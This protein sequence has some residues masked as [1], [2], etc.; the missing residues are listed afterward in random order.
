MGIVHTLARLY[1]TSQIAYTRAY[2]L[3]PSVHPFVNRSSWESISVFSCFVPSLSPF[4]PLTDLKHLEQP[5]INYRISRS[6]LSGM[7]DAQQCRR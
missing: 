6:V 5:T 2:R 4:A 7:I 1:T 3:Q